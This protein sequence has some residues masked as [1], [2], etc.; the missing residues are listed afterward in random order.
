MCHLIILP[1]VEMNTE[2]SVVIFISLFFCS[3]FSFSQ[4]LL[5]QTEDLLPSVVTLLMA[6]PG[7][8]EKRGVILQL[9]YIFLFVQIQTGKVHRSLLGS[10]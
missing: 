6:F 1:N 4:H 7:N 9:L 8:T 3:V 10:S 5:G 2:S